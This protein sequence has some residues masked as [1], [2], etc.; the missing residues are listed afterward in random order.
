MASV[1][2]AG[3]ADLVRVFVQA[4]LAWRIAHVVESLGVGEAAAREEVARIDEARRT[5]ARE[6]YRVTWGDPRVY[7]LVLDS[8]RFGV[9]GS[10]DVIVAA[11]RAAGG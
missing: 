7:D 5:Y 9:E 1:V 11:V 4:P 8:S 10:A 3:R 6:G 2:L